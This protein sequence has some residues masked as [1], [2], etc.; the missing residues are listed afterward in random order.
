[1]YRQKFY[2]AT[3]KI[4]LTTYHIICSS[5]ENWLNADDFEKANSLHVASREVRLYTLLQ[6]ASKH[7]TCERLSLWLIN[8]RF[9]IATVDTPRLSAS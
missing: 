1:M 4:K 5:Q 6:L 9:V 3:S 2:L 8:C 7:G